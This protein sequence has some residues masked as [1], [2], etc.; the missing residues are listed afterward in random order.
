VVQLFW[1][2]RVSL[3]TTEV[4][5]ASRIVVSMLAA[6]LVMPGV[7]LAQRDPPATEPA[8]FA[9]SEEYLDIQRRALNV[10]RNILL[11]MA[12]SMPERLYR[13]RA[14]PAQRDFAQQIHHVVSSSVLVANWWGQNVNRTDFQGDTATVFNSRSALKAYINWGY[15]DLEELLVSQ[16][17]EDRDTRVRFFNGEFMPRWQVWDELHQHAF[18]TLGQVVANF[19][20]HGMAPPAF[21]F[22]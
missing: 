15:D 4:V 11:A 22:F 21:L 16:T 9:M 7:G 12:D 19:R 5:M 1:M 3:L 2:S 20:K 6:L 13:D 8:T 18:W 10:Q 14:T 17:A